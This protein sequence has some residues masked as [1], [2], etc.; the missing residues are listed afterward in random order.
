MSPRRLLY[1]TP[2][3]P[4]MT[5]VGAL[6][7]LKF[8]R[9]L[10]SFGWSSVVLCDLRRGDA[11]SSALLEAVPETTKV[12]WDYGRQAAANKQRYDA[13]AFGQAKAEASASPARPGLAKRLAAKIPKAWIPGPE[14]VPLNEHSLDI[15]HALAAARRVL[16]EHPCDAI[17]VNADPY[18]ALLVG[19]RLARQTGLPLVADLRDPWALCSLRRPK[20]LPP[21]R[22][23]V[24]AL[25]RRVFEQ[26]SAVIL[27]TH[28]ARR[29]YLRH[30][31]DL[32]ASRFYTI[33]NHGD[34]ELVSRGSY[35]RFGRFTMLFLG[36]FRRFVEGDNLLEALAELRARG[37]TGAEIGLVV[38]GRCPESALEKARAL[39][40]EDMLDSHPFVPYVEVGSFMASADLLISLSNDTE[41]RIP[42]KIFDYATTSRPMLV[43]GDTR[44]LVEMMR[45]FPGAQTCGR[46]DVQGIA[47]AMQAAY[48][49]GAQREIDRSHAGLDSHSA[50]AQLAEILAEVTQPSSRRAAK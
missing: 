3:F 48:E 19:A 22:A 10:P 9:H 15:P 42:A 23:L 35:P 11:V 2:Y 44:E 29:D 28:T 43:I 32:P 14:F 26:A 20:R 24:D 41:Q 30:Y 1:I 40:V 36:N 50:T 46:T 34:A 49:A 18:A 7:P 16:A 5:R 27:N 31:F 33:Y 4:P 25:E 47:D 13:G 37:L 21:Q 12:V 39:G 6:R 45:E 8:V 38:S 17:M